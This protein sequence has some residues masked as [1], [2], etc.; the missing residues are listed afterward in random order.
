MFSLASELPWTHTTAVFHI[1]DVV[2]KL[3]R[4]NGLTLVQLSQ[5]ASVSK[6]TLSGLERNGENFERDTLRKIAGALGTTE[7]ALYELLRAL[8]APF[9]AELI[10]ELTRKEDLGSPGAAEEDADSA[11]HEGSQ[12]MPDPDQV[13]GMITALRF[14]PPERRDEFVQFCISHALGLRQKRRATGTDPNG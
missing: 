2:R 4:E 3:R 12:E 13:H 14:A 5:R 7:G 1:G 11:T 6:T 9:R 10:R 8:Q